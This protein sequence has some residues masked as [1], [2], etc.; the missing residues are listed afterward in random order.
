MYSFYF[1]PNIVSEI[2]LFGWAVYV[3]RMEEVRNA[4]LQKPILFI[5]SFCM[6][7]KLS[8]ILLQCEYKEKRC[9]FKWNPEL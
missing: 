8:S 2:Q 5:Y 9:C 7:C 6:L 3:V 4:I 1:L